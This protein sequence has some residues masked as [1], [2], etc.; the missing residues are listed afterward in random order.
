MPR[1]SQTSQAF[2]AVPGGLVP[3]YTA[4]AVSPNGDVVDAGKVFVLVKNSSASSINVTVTATATVTGLAVGNMVVSV[5]AG[6]EEMIGPFPKQT[7]GQPNGANQSGGNDA[8]RVYVD[9]S[10]VASVT[11]AVIAYT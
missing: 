4:P 1:A 8:G 11:R 7:F 6:A 2:G 10:A 9:Y 3:N 5:A